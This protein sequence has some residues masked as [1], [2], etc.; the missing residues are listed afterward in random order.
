MKYYKFTFILLLLT[1]SAVAEYKLVGCSIDM[2]T[3]HQLTFYAG[4]S[5]QEF[6]KAVQNK[7][8][9]KVLKHGIMG[10]Q[11]NEGNIVE[12]I[13]YGA[14]VQNATELI[15]ALFKNEHKK[16]TGVTCYIAATG[17]E[18]E[19]ARRMETVRKV[20]ATYETQD[21]HPLH[22]NCF[23]PLKEAWEAA[24]DRPMPAELILTN[25]TIGMVITRK[26]C[27]CVIL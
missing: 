9:V 10:F 27:P 5:L 26:F 15:P 20:Y 24:G 8:P 14:T 2:S 7:S 22:P 21:W 12:S 1:N 25:Y 17:D 6:A 18:V 13:G 11:N 3:M 23:T 19:I 4:N 16:A